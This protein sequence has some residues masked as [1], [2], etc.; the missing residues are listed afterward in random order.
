MG[1][2]STRFG[3]KPLMLIGITLSGLAFLMFSRLGLETNYWV[4]FFPAVII[5]GLGLA[6]FVVPLTAVALTALPDR[7]SGISSG[8][9]NAVTRIAQMLAIAIFG[10]ILASGFRAAL[11]DHTNSLPLDPPVRDHLIAD[12]RNLG[13]IEFPPSLPAA[14][15]DSVRL[16]VRLSLVDSS[17]TL[18]YVCAALCVLAALITII[19]IREPKP[20]VAD[21]ASQGT[22]PMVG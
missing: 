18:M 1:R 16:A 6:F 13:A 11:I 14:Q 3:A 19:F 8:V 2:L 5:Y 10:A 15:A 4:S 12:S 9:S 20:Y 7:F 21:E 22:H 17:R